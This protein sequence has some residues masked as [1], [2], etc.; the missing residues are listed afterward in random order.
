MKPNV[1]AHRGDK[2]SIITEH[3][4]TEDEVM[5]LDPQLPIEVPTVTGD[6]GESLPTIA[7]S[8]AI[9][10]MATTLSR[11]TGFARTWAMAAALGATA[12]ASAYNVSNNIPNLIF[13]LVVGG[14]LGSLFIPTFT[15]IKNSQGKEAAWRFTSHILNM[16]VLILGIVAILGT[17][18]PFPFIWTQTFK[19]AAADADVVRLPA[20]F[21]F[22]FFAIQVVIYGIGMVIQSVLNAQRKY[23]WTSLGPVFNNVVVIA[24]FLYVARQP[25]LGTR[26]LVVLGAGTTL[27]VVTM[28]AVMVPALFKSGFTY[29]FELGLRDPY[30]RSL[31]KLAGPAVLF[32]VTDMITLSFRNSSVLAVSAQG[33]SVIAYA[34]MW[35]TLPYGILAVAVATAVF[36]ELSHFSSRKDISGFKRTLSQGLRSTALLILPCAA[37]LFALAEPICSLFITG[38]FSTED[39]L[40]VARTLR[41][42]S[43]GL[44]FY[45]GMM[46]ML[47]A[48][49]SLK[50]TLT[51]A[52]ANMG[53]SVVQVAGYVILTAGIGS[54]K[55]FGISGAPLAD[56]TFY[57]AVFAT[58][59]L[60]LRKKIGSFSLSTLLSLFI[61]MAL[62]SSIAGALA[63]WIS[64]TLS[65]ALPG[66]SGSVLQVAG[67]GSIG[68]TV[69]FGLASIL[70]IDEMA[71]VRTIAHRFI[72]K[73]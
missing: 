9:M 49:Y 37:L 5:Q 15:D 11:L 64:Q 72:G 24:T 58:L 47:G 41:I 68:L 29:H 35:F 30:V 43:I 20:Q 55:G 50:D 44:V 23:L 40:L 42:W 33:A 69:A 63:W 66:I 48:F 46:F 65:G 34:W 27:G 51:P 13:E 19:M 60:V 1:K 45:A 6:G 53:W 4:S 3:T 67:A 61:R 12:I 36:T 10:S 25:T 70:R 17:L 56:I 28:F 7:R 22:R 21:L 54:W 52:L 16:G 73:K 62:A 31:L 32:A 38:R 18:F 14:V 39:M 71:Y 26:E 59:L 57:V 2:E 8:T